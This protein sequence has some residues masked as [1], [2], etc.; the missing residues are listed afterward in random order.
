MLS[1]RR[2]LYP[3]SFNPVHY[4]HLDIARRAVRL[5]DEVIIAVYVHPNKVDLFSGEERVALLREALQDEPHLQV[6]TYNQLTVDYAK[7]VGAGTIVRG[8]RVFSDFELEFRMALANRRLAPEI[9]I[10]NFIAAEQHLHISSSTVREIASLSGDVST[11]AP[12]H[13]VEALKRRFEELRAKGSSS[14]YVVS[15]GD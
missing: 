4:G 1:I 7:E 9:E 12:P 13:V 10:I 14:S 6:A 8:L 5:F 11:M 2:A 3:G 15:L